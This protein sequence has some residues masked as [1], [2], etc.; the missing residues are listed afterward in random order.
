MQ[1]VKRRPEE[2]FMSKCMKK[3]LNFPARTMMWGGNQVHGTSRRLLI[4][5][6]MINQIKYIEVLNS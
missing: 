1:T 3:T 2:E 5:V 4:V 6:G